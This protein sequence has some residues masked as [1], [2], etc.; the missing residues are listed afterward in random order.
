MCYIPLGKLLERDGSSREMYS[1][2]QGIV[3]HKA[4]GKTVSFL[5]RE[6]ESE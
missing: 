5:Y 4:V 2:H 6:G 1:S 3:N